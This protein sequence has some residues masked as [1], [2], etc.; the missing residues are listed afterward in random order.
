[1]GIKNEIIKLKILE[2]VIVHCD[3]SCKSEFKQY[4]YIFQRR[5]I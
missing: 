5:V 3:Y 4:K 1:M 2:Y